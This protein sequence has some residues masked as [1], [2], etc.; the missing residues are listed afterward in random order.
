MDEAVN[1]QPTVSS[2]PEALAD[3]NR[4]VDKVDSEIVMFAPRVAKLVPPRTSKPAKVREKA[5]IVGVDGSDE[6]GGDVVTTVGGG[7]G[8]GATGGGAS[9]GVSGG[10]ARV[11]G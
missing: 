5:L 2:D 10:G 4:R 7:A 11:G 8:A 1:L 3:E 9:S 6:G